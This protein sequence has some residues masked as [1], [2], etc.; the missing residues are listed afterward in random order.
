MSQSQSSSPA[1][2][3]LEDGTVL[4]GRSIGA[5]GTSIG[6]L[7]FNTSLSG[8]QE[9][10]TDPSYRGQ[11]VLLTYPLIGNYGIC[12]EDDESTHPWLSGLVVR[13]AS[14]VASNFRA[15]TSLRSYLVSQE[16]VAIDGVDTRLLTRKVR[17]GG[18]M[19]VL[20]T[21]DPEASDEELLTRVR[22]AP[23][24]D[25][26]DLVREVTSEQAVDW[27]V[28]YESEFS[29]KPTSSPDVSER[30]P[31]VAIDCGIKRNILR[32]LVEYGFEVRV[33]PASAS[34]EQ[35][36]AAS[37]RGLFLSNGPGDPSAV[38]YLVDTV[39]R[40][41]VDEKLPTFG[42]C[43]GHQI[44]SRVLGG[45]TFKMRFGHHGANHPV[46]ELATGRID[47]T[48]QNHSYAVDADSMPDGVEVTHL[49]LN[50]GT[51]EG[52]RHK[53]LPVWSVQYHPEAAPGPHDALGLFARFRAMFDQT[54]C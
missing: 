14:R 43:L 12:P 13:E 33:V 36:L 16:V 21:T 6:E 48:S 53:E 4:H 51:V 5:Q 2:L 41:V 24:T 7:V 38:P 42:I 32:S 34:A 37:P 29:P 10:L 23:G 1:R 30:I 54:P 3:V 45:T 22:A 20:L 8:Y 40:L 35:I 26:I 17:S 46:K 9:I 39:K 44:L 18:E 15:G 27:T 31:V 47:I 25:G 49:N 19:K 11:V 50:D 28:G 52:I